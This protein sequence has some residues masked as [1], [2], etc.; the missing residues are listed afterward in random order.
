MKP[1]R[2]RLRAH[3]DRVGVNWPVLERDY[4]ISWL[5]AGISRSETLRET[6]VLKGGTALK[7]C[8]FGDYRFSEDLDFTSLP[9]VPRGR[10]LEDAFQSAADTAVAL[11]LPYAPVSIYV[12]RYKERDPHPGDQEAFVFRTQFPWHPEPLCRT[13]VEITTDEPILNEPVHRQLIHQYEEPMDNR[14]LVY[15]LEEI[16]AEK[17][18]SI[19]Q[20]AARRRRRGWDR[21]RARDYYDLWRILDEYE[22]EIQVERVPNLVADKCRVRSVAFEGVDD[23][24]PKAI[25]REVR[26]SWRRW[27]GP[28]DSDLPDFEVV[29]SELQSKLGRLLNR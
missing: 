12:E 13:M 6:I 10:D 4:V 16:L 7:K 15:S 3:R 29:T 18:R 8:Y 20:S 2:T 1:L 17:L 25:V 9:G 14:V 28:L 24:F 27:L 19:L 22:S 21:N 11:L 5:L 23:F 26:D